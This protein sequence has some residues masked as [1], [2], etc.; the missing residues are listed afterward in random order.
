MPWFLDCEA[1]SLS[2][3]SYPVEIAWSDSKGKIESHLINPYLYPENYTDWD[4]SAQR[5]HGLTRA[6]LA[7]HG[8]DPKF[9][10][11]RLNSILATKI[12]FSDAPDFD[13]FWCDRLFEAF[14]IERKFEFNHF[15]NILKELLPDEYWLIDKA[16]GHTYISALYRQARD[17]CGLV[18]HR[19]AND[20]AFMV[21]LYKLARKVSV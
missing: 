11:E 15:E 6:Y 13:A 1:S 12:V 17:Q 8:E 16:T 7:D 18:R 20:V 10:A 19:A 14:G 3:S 2:D 5:V 4:D 9:I 21:E